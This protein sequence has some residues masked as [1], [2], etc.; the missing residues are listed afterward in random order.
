VVQPPQHRKQGALAG[1]RLAHDGDE[2]A[3]LDADVDA[4]QGLHGLV[5]ALV[6]LGEVA[7]FD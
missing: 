7:Y 5:A 1:A 6:A 3:R 2:L 4:L